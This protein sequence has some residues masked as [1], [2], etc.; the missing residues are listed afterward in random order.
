[1]LAVLQQNY[2]DKTAILSPSMGPDI[3]SKVGQPVCK[4]MQGLT[5]N[6][7]Q[8]LTEI[9]VHLPPHIG[10]VSMSHVHFVLVDHNYFIFVF[11]GFTKHTDICTKDAAAV[12]D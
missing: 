4:V 2:Q 9:E 1:M 12:S 10:L 3:L 8:A 6:Q 11:S 5:N 7:H